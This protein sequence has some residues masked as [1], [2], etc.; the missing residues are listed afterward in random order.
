MRI[1]IPVRSDEGLDSHVFPHFGRAPCLAFVD[2]T[3]NACEV[4]SNTVHAHGHGHGH[5]VPAGTLMTRGVDAVICRRLG[6][7]AFLNLSDAGV[8][9]YVSRA[10]LVRDVL[11]D[12]QEGGLGSPGLD[13]LCEGHH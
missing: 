3:S 10:H 4:V 6:Q 8:Q 2:T 12:L 7:R 11:R 1:C 9:V 13:E 5:C